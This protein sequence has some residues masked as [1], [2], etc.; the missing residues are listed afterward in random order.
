MTPAQR[1]AASGTGTLSSTAQRTAD[2][3]KY[4]ATKS[5]A[6]KHHTFTL[7][8]VAAGTAAPGLAVFSRFILRGRR[9]AAGQR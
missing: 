5:M 2:T 8:V 3:S 7:L 9:Q 1:T 4:V 6:A